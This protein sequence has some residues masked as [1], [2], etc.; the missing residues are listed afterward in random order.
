MPFGEPSKNEASEPAK[1]IIFP[2]MASD[3]DQGNNLYKKSHG[4]YAP[5]EQRSRDYKWNI[6]PNQTRFGRKGDTIALNGVSTNIV[7]VLHDSS[8]NTRSAVN[9]KQ[10]RKQIFFFYL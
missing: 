2:E 5:G 9:L 7:D 4:S 10:V 3:I 1:D 8:V 6:D